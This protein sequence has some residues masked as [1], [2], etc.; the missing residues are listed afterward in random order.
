MK[1]AFVSLE[2]GQTAHS[3]Y[4][5]EHLCQ[6]SVFVSFSFIVSFS[7]SF[8]CIASGQHAFVQL[9]E[10]AFI[11]SG[12]LEVVDFKISFQHL[13][14]YLHLKDSNNFLHILVLQRQT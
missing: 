8:L 6:I 3:Y 7:V 5:V 9:C 1:L 4:L 14:L 12:Y 10:L 13:H 2:C 11:H